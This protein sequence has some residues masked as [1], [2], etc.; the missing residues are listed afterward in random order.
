MKHCAA[1]TAF[2]KQSK[3]SAGKHHQGIR[4]SIRGILPQLAELSGSAKAIQA[5]I[6]N[7]REDETLEEVRSQLYE[8]N[9]KQKTIDRL[10]SEAST[11]LTRLAEH[12]RDTEACTERIE[13][14][15]K[16]A[17]IAGAGT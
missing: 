2:L 10:A 9:D 5:H 3:T 6:H 17:P 16:L 12:L 15:A 4:A 14:A 13:G 8:A 7:A 1:T 11:A